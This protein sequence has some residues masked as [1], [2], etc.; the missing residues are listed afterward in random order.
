MEIDEIEFRENLNKLT[1]L[2]L[3]EYIHNYWCALKTESENQMNDKVNYMQEEFGGIKMTQV[4]KMWHLLMF[5]NI[6][7]EDKK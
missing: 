5:K 4:N 7:G 3:V 1:K 6:K 2:E